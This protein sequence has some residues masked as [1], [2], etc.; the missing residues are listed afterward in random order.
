MEIS[1]RRPNKSWVE[2]DVSIVVAGITIGVGHGQ[3]SNDE[4]SL[5]RIIVEEADVPATVAEH[6]AVFNL[7][8]WA[9]LKVDS[10]AIGEGDNCAVD[11]G[12]T[13]R[14]AHSCSRLC[15]VA[16]NCAV[17][18]DRR[19]IVTV[20]SSAEVGRVVGNQ[21]IGETRRGLPAMHPATDQRHRVVADVAICEGRRRAISAHYPTKLS[22]PRI[23]A[24]LAACETRGAHPTI[25][26]TSAPRCV[27]RNRACVENSRRQTVA[28]DSAAVPRSGV[29]SDGAIREQRRAVTEE[30][31]AAA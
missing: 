6:I 5:C 14:D 23:G 21:A 20:Q 29:A 31:S 10:R 11:G 27:S 17:S 30:R 3:L 8:C 15:R 13:E 22:D 18:Q 25:Y 16:V 7:T 24:D 19:R 28:I 26:T 12:R 2:E 9:G 1:A 4:W